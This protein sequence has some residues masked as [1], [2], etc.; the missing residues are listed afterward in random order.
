MEAGSPPPVATLRKASTDDVPRVARALARAFYDDPVFQWLI[1]DGSERL[2]RS[3]RGFSL[4][5]RKV[6]LPHDECYTT[7]DVVGGALWMP[8]GTWHLGPLA[9]LRLLPGMFRAMGGRLP[10]VL[11]AIAT[12]ESN[13]PEEPHWYLHMIGVDPRQQG[14]GYGAA[15]LRNALERVDA[16][17]LTAYLESSN[18][19]N[20]PIYERF[21]FEVITAVTVDPAPP[22]FPMLRR[23]R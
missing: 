4:Y 2:R 3:E 11:R 21:G 5:M 13:H 16:E 23:A 14:R 6:Y 17:H 19:V 15:L 18:P 20:I 12:I 1:P 10:Q 22:I 8:P 9:Q 7:E